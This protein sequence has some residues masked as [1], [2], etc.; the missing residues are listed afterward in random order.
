MGSGE[1]AGKLASFKSTDQSMLLQEL[2]HFF[3]Q[4]SADTF[5]GGNFIHRGLTQAIHRAELSQQQILAVLTY[6]GAI[7]KNAF[8]NPFFHEQLVIC[9]GEAVRLVA[10][11]L[12]QTQGAGVHRKLQRQ[13]P[14]RPVNL[15]PFLAFRRRR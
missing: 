14:A 11:A 2:M 9:V 3:G 15:F 6:P 7:V 5:R 12:K 10:N 13:G 4:L 1:R 8:A